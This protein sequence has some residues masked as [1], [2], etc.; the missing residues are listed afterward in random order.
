MG[1]LIVV[2]DESVLLGGSQPA[3]E[4]DERDEAWFVRF[5]GWRSRWALC[6]QGGRLRESRVPE[7]QQFF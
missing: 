2:I 1:G 5:G 3:Y 6:I 7:T 4:G